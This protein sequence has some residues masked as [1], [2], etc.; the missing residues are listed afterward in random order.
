MGTSDL[1]LWT[2]HQTMHQSL[3]HWKAETIM[4]HF[5]NKFHAAFQEEISADLL[6][7]EFLSQLTACTFSYAFLASFLL[8]ECFSPFPPSPTTPSQV[9]WGLQRALQLSYK[10]R[11]CTPSP[12]STC[13]FRKKTDQSASQQDQANRLPWSPLSCMAGSTSLP[14]CQV[15]AYPEALRP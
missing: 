14:M 13:T 1:S 3:L 8:T 15:V 2:H 6:L 7:P 11:S 12:P 5:R 4:L 10:M 9:K